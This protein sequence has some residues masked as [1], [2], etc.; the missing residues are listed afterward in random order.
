MRLARWYQ[1]MLGAWLLTGLPLLILAYGFVGPDMFSLSTLVG[2]FKFD[3]TSISTFASSLL[4]RLLI[5][6]P[7]ILIP[8]ALRR[9]GG[10]TS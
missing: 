4:P 1:V 9:K 7:I 6:A 2:M 3:V 8:F 5:F 10:A